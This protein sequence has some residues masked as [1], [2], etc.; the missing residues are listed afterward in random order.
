MCNN[1]EAQKNWNKTWDSYDSLRHIM[2]ITKT[3]LWVWTSRSIVPRRSRLEPILGSEAVRRKAVPTPSCDVS[4]WHSPSSDFQTLPFSLGKSSAMPQSSI[5]LWVSIKMT[6][7]SF[8]FVAII[9]PRFGVTQFLK[10]GN[11]SP[12]EQGRTRKNSE[13]LG[14]F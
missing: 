2:T 14:R 10:C 13:E 5:I 7:I 12:E 11:A 4:V 6:F 9:S 8:I 3:N 1:W